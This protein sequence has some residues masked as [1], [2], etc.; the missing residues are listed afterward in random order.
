MDNR[1]QQTPSWKAQGNIAAQTPAAILRKNE[2]HFDQVYAGVNLDR[3]VE[4]ARNVEKFLANALKVDTSWRSLYHDGFAERLNGKQV[5]ELGSGD[6]LNALI[7]AGL[8]AQVVANDISSESAR[9]INTAAARLGLKNI[10]TVT[11]DF[12]KLDFSPGSF[13][14]VIGKAFLHHLTPETEA[15]YLP[16]VAQ[17]LKPDGEARFFEPAMNSAWLDQLRWMIPVPKRPSKLSKVAFAEWKRNDPHPERDNSSAH[18]IRLGQSL[19]SE[20]RIVPIGSLERFCRLIPT[21]NSLRRA[22]RAR[23]Y[24]VEATL[25]N[26]FQFKAARAQLIVY[27]APKWAAK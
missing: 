5:F 21:G 6:G 20:V 25:P 1:S 8:G 7:M 3:L 17:L 23:A 2:E 22:Y 4:K 24:Q 14:Y 15:E 13:D 11:G 9:L 26:W 12:S 19:F 16:K 10:K 27:R 18:F